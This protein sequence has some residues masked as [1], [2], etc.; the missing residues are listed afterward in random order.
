MRGEPAWQEDGRRLLGDWPIEIGLWVGSAASPNRLGK[1]GDGRDDTAVARVRRLPAKRPRSA[2]ADQGMPLVRHAVRP[3]QLLLHAERRGS[4]T[5]Q[6]SV[7]TVT[8]T[9]NTFWS[10]QRTSRPLRKTSV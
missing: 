3:G 7:G 2:R 10:G 6:P 1:T 9:D 4:P 5:V 8:L